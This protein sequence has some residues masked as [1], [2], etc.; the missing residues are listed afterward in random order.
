MIEELSCKCVRTALWDSAAGTLDETDSLMIDLHSAECPECRLHRAE[1]RSLRT[2]L[3]NLPAA[4]VTPLLST[5][6]KVLA[7]RERSRS[8]LRR[9]VAAR[10]E[11]LKSSAKLILDNLLRPVAVP[12]AGG[13]LASF[14]CF[15]VIV[16]NLH[17][18][19]EW[20][21]GWNDIPVGLFSQVTLDDASPFSVRG[22]DVI[23]ELTVDRNGVVSDFEVPQCN[24]TGAKSTSPEEL[25]EIG[26]LV[27]YSKFSPATAF[28][29]KVTG[30]ILVSIH[31]I[32]IRG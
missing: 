23:V 13:L 16:D 1:V 32:N 21:P 2:G 15:G 10:M 6:L 20:Q 7:S 5:R 26:N 4:G 18:H 24:D 8:L 12:A 31:H 14:L 22:K 28:G 30:K 3:K 17:V 19:P 25:Q 9:D 27:L 29:K 11:E